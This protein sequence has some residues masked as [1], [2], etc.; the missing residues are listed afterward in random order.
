MYKLKN[1]V[2]IVI[3]WFERNLMK[4]NP[5]QFTVMFLT[6]TRA[7][8]DFPEYLLVNDVSIARKN[9]TKLLGIILGNK[10]L[11]HKHIE[12]LCAKASIYN[13]MP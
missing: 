3:D 10:L 4:A 11:Y 13:L 12:Q 6:P 5:D 7:V 9:V 8:D 1:D 2:T